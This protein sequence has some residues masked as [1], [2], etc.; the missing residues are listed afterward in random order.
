MTPAPMLPLLRQQFRFRRTTDT[1]LPPLMGSAWRGAVGHALRHMV[2]VTG[3]PT[4]DGCP[5]MPTCAYAEIFEAPPPD[6]ALLLSGYPTAPH[7][8]VVH[9]HPG[10]PRDPEA[11]VDLTLIG[12]STRHRELLHHAMLRAAGKGVANNTWTLQ[13]H[14]H[15]HTWPEAPP[16]PAS[17][18]IT[19]VTPLRLRVDN[20]YLRPE[21][22][23]FAAFFSTLLR[24]LTQLHALHGNGPPEVDA[25]ALVALARA[26]PVHLADLHWVEQRRYSS[27]QST[28]MPMSGIVGSFVIGAPTGGPLHSFWPWLW[29]GQN[30]HVGKLCAMGLG[31]YTVAPD[32]PAG[33]G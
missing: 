9:V 4:C 13:H 33:P 28:Q 11:R 32:T 19:L 7:P 10:H 25:K 12:R 22:F 14:Q 3:K 20:R 30:T 15:H 26:Q 27:R 23:T 24:R 2:C 17:A 16:V 29:Q 1:A 8:Y 31:H 5:V 18:R 6:D 21:H